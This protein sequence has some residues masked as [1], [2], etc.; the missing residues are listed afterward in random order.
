MP[1][2]RMVMNVLVGSSLRRK[3]GVFGLIYHLLNV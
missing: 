1:K 3:L 2:M